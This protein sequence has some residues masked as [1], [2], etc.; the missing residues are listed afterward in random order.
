MA[1]RVDRERSTGSHL[2]N[3]RSQV[4]S[5]LLTFLEGVSGAWVRKKRVRTAPRRGLIARLWDGARRRLRRRTTGGAA[6]KGPRRPKPVARVGVMASAMSEQEKIQ[7][8]AQT[9]A[10]G[11]A[12]EPTVSD[13]AANPAGPDAPPQ[14]Q[15]PGGESTEATPG[16]VENAGAV[17]EDVP[18]DAD[19][20][21]DAP[22]LDAGADEPFDLEDDGD[23]PGGSDFDDVSDAEEPHP[24]DEDPDVEDS[25]DLDD[26]PDAEESVDPGDE[27][28]LEDGLESDEEMIDDLAEALDDSDPEA[29]ADDEISDGEDIDAEAA[30][31]VPSAEPDSADVETPGEELP[32]AEVVEEDIS[33]EAP[34]ED[35]NSVD[36]EAAG[37]EE[38]P[39]SDEGDEAAVETVSDDVDAEAPESEEVAEPQPTEGSEEEANPEVSAEDE[40]VEAEDDATEE[41]DTMEAGED[42]E[43]EDE[44]DDQEPA[45]ALGREET[46]QTIHALLFASDRPLSADRIAEALGDIERD[47]VIMLIE[48]LKA[49]IA[50][51]P[52]PYL[53]RS[54]AGGYQ[55][56]TRPD[57]GPYIR[58]LYQ[59]KKSNRLSKSVLE[60]LAIIAYKQPVTRPAVEA[61]RGVSVSHAF[62]I[63][64]EKRLIKVSGVAELPGRPKL[65]RTTDEFLM[66]FGIES[67][68]EL[69]SIE[70]IREMG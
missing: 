15:E 43:A 49:Q 32:A 51:L 16:A 33:V 27:P 10:E 13:G 54:I 31:E 62:D 1:L 40:A 58:R 53:L 25:V 70:E 18:P 34:F 9:A 8:S 60:T 5:A 45:P 64:Q 66:H 17:V 3:I 6:R 11:F 37:E 59:I 38:D 63:L 46:L 44:L 26:T 7:E 69:P 19:S 56:T 52:V 67:L 30:E 55:L 12:A 41:P 24:S 29:E 68:K 28:G 65:Y 47:V 36:T 50:E 23:G 21:A 42:E 2:D 48:E 20:E 39:A 4:K 22:D 57:F 61:I 14:G 35:S